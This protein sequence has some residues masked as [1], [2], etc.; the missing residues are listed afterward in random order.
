[1]PYDLN[2]PQ[3]C[4]E[5]AEDQA[6]RK[7]D[8]PF[9]NSAGKSVLLFFLFQNPHTDRN[10]KAQCGPECSRDVDPAVQPQPG[11]VREIFGEEES[12][13]V[14]RDQTAENSRVEAD[15]RKQ[16]DNGLLERK[17]EDRDHD[18]HPRDGGRHR[19]HE[20]KR[21]LKFAAKSQ[22]VSDKIIQSAD[23]RENRKYP[24]NHHIHNYPPYGKK[25]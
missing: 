5:T 25:N 12:A 13:P 24:G 22:F 6:E 1:M 4:G 18:D 10:G 9:Q 21:A 8:K 14:D 20:G 19:P 7:D 2:K 3:S 16:R 17:R 23:Q 15:Q 11:I